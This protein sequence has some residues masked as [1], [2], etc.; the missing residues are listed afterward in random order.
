MIRPG[1]RIAV[2]ALAFASVVPGSVEAA[3][4][5]SGVYLMGLRGPG[6]AITPPEGLFLNNQFY[7][8]DAK[9]K[10]AISLGGRR[11]AP[12]A[13]V[14]AFVNLATLTWMTPLEVL[15][16]RV[17]VFGSLPGG[18]VNVRAGLGPLQVRESTTAIADPSVGGF[19]GWKAGNFHFQLGTAG[20]IPIGD[21]RDGA[22]AN[23]AKHRGALDFYAA[24]TW[25]DPNLG[26]SITGVAGYTVNWKNQKT[27]Y[28]TGNELHFEAAISQKL[29]KEFSIGVVGYHYQQVT[30]DSGPGA[31][32]GS[33]KGRASAIGG[34]AGYTFELGKLP[35]AVQVRYYKE[36]DVKHRFKGDAGFLSI[37]MPLWVPGR[38]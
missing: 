10:R 23:V 3:E 5:G 13:D 20:F 1:V 32:L 34:M 6:A 4:G 35:V 27:D 31:A 22:I 14:S 36:V 16:G 11:V 9:A 21:Y 29:T 18:V 30:G 25:A 12:N 24:T 2:T 28:R 7:V 15:G 19:I 17:G 26:L 38:T 8:Y 33:F 37:S